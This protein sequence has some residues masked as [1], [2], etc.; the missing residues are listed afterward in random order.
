MRKRGGRRVTARRA[1]PA[2]GCLHPPL[3][4]SCRCLAKQPERRPKSAADAL[5]TL[6]NVH[7]DA[8]A[9]RVEVRW[10]GWSRAS[11]WRSRKS[12][13]VAAGILAALALAIP[14]VRAL[15]ARPAA[16]L[17]QVVA[18]IPFRISTADSTLAWLSEGMVEL[19]TVRL[20]GEGGIQV[21]EPGSVLS[22]WH[23]EAPSARV[24]Q[25]SLRR[26]SAAANAGRIIEGS[27]T[28]TSRDVVLTAWILSMPG[29][30]VAA[31]ATAE[32]SPD[33]LPFLV[34]RLA[35]QLLGLTAGFDESRLA[36]LTSTSL[37]AIRAYLAGRASVRAGRME[38][39]L[40]Q[41]RAAVG[42]DSTFALAALALARGALQLTVDPEDF[43]RGK[44]LA[45]SSEHRLSAV[46]RALLHV[47]ALDWTSAQ[48]LFEKAHAAVS[49]YPDRPEFWYG[50]GEAYLHSGPPAGIDSSFERAAYA[51]RRGWQLDSVAS[52]NLL[53]LSTPLVAEPVRHMVELA[54]LRGDTAEVRALSSRV[55]AMDST[56]ELAT[57]L[58]WH[59]AVSDGESARHAF[60][61]DLGR[62]PERGVGRIMLFMLWTG[63]GAEDY[64]RAIAERQRSLEADGLRTPNARMETP[65]NQGRP[66]KV[67]RQAESSARGPRAEIRDA[68]HNALY[69]GGD[70]IAGRDAARQ[71]ARWADAPTMEGSAA[72]PQYQDICTV[73]QWRAAHGD[74][75]AANTASRRL[76]AAGLA[77][78]TANDSVGRV[79]SLCAALLDASRATA[80]ALPDARAR[81]L[82]ADSLA[83]ASIFEACCY[84][85]VSGSNLLLARLW[86]RQGDLPRALQAVRRRSARFLRMPNYLS[87]FVREEGRLAALTGDRDGAIRAYRHYLALRYD[88]EPALRPEADRVRRELAALLRNH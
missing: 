38:D 40:P 46:D 88:P 15:S 29:G 33:S 30:R 32:G 60:W 66:S 74:M 21:A 79:L 35:G 54:Q 51:F 87:S 59:R 62:G 63:I 77:R 17:S 4:A 64:G 47:T 49:A 22:A 12:S 3:P 52:G 84:G 76:R 43:G 42:M 75:A 44:R 85:S 86:E 6:G 71:L 2:R 25:E 18:V 61:D 37:P 72:R 78:L 65:L 41:F 80:L 8:P 34:D 45:L 5:R 16:A 55:L 39:A 10:R 19:L 70:T 24:R 27:V 28:G 50:L 53:S 56:S 73:G 81:L 1:E 31:Q 68:I 36:T 7:G 26:V 48:E 14:G 83:R 11:Q 82:V 9:D 13:C 69:W 58:R 23:R 57:V 20:A 67:V